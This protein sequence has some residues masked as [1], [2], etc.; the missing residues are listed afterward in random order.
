MRHPPRYEDKSYPNYI[1][2]LDKALYAPRAWFTKLSKKLFDIGFRGSKADTSL[3]Y[4][5]KGDLSMCILVYVDDIIVVS[6]RQEV[7]TALP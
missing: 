6:S 4:Y 3:F 2:K 5:S 1:C 7:V